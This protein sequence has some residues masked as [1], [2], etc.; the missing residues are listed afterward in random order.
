MFKS[1][2]KA[3]AYAEPTHTLDFLRQQDIILLQELA[4]NKAHE[5]A[6]ALLSTHTVWYTT[7]ERYRRGKG[8]AIALHNKLTP[9]MHSIR[10]LNDY[11]FMHLQLKG[12]LPS[13][14]DIIHIICCYIPHSK[15]T[16]LQDLDLMARFNQLTEMI[17]TITASQPNGLIIVAGDFNAKVGSELSLSSKAMEAIIDC[18]ASAC[19]TAQP[20][21]CRDQRHPELDYSGTLLNDMCS[22]THMINLTGLTQGDSPAAA[23]FVSHQDAQARHRLDHVLVSPST[24]AYLQ[25]HQVAQHILGSDHL[26]VQLSLDLTHTS[27]VSPVE[28]V[29]LMQF[30]PSRNA[31]VIQKYISE[32]ASMGFLAQMRELAGSGQASAD[33]LSSAMNSAITK[34]A[35]AAGYR[36]RSM[37]EQSPS[38]KA[39]RTHSKFK[40]WHDDKCKQ[41]QQQIRSL[42]AQAQDPLD[43][44]QLKALQQVYRS[45]VKQLLRKHKAVHAKQQA[46]AWRKNRNSFWRW[47]K[48]NGT[49]C[50]F[51]ARTIAEHFN[52]KLNSFPGAPAAPSFPNEQGQQEALGDITS[53][54]PS[55]PEIVAAIKRMDSVAAGADG[56]PTA[57]Y[58]PSLSPSADDQAPA[59][60]PSQEEQSSGEQAVAN[61]AEGLHLIYA[62]ISATRRVPLEWRTALLIPI[63][64]GKGQL[65][66]LSSYRPLSVPTVACR[67]WSCIMNQRL[68]TACKDILPDTMFG[69]RP[70]RRTSDPLFVLRHLIDMH[71]ADKGNRFAVAFMDLSG[72]YD[73]I[74]RERLFHKLKH[75]GMSD[76][77]ISTLKHLYAGTQCIV[78]CEKGTHSPFSIGVGLR[79][80]CPL[81]TT[82]FNLYIWDLHK[83]LRSTGAGVRIGDCQSA[84][85]QLI[86]DLAYADDVA[87]CGSN[88]QQLQH[89]IDKFQ[90]YCKENGLAVNPDK[91]E[92]V[93]FAKNSRAW[94]NHQWHVDSVPLPKS[95]KFKYLGVELHGTQGIKAAMQQRYSCMVAAQSTINRRLRELNAPRDPALIADLFDAITAASGSYGCEI[96]STPF[97]HDWHLRDCI[98]QRYQCSVYKHALGVRR[99]TGSLLVLLEMGRYPLQISW[100]QRTINYWN[101]LVIDKAN[102]KILGTCLADNVLHGVQEGLTCWSKELLDGLRFVAPERDWKTHMSQL[103]PIESAKGIALLA[104]RKFVSDAMIKFDGDP[105]EP[106]C[107]YRQHNSYTHWMYVTPAD[108]MLRP[109]SYVGYSM[110][111]QRKQAIAR[112]RLGTAQV[113]VHTDHGTPYQQRICQRCTSGAVDSIQHLL[114]ECEHAGLQALR[115][116]QHQDLQP[117][118]VSVKELMRLAYDD[119]KTECLSSYLYEVMQFIC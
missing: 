40:V 86:T 6:Q 10:I 69:F 46:L 94:L 34:A 41:L 9:H 49:H 71:K 108:G 103:L 115:Q 1:T 36:S 67:I 65:A 35:K 7:H 61:I 110:P 13:P 104:K 119:S 33:Q 14:T 107:P 3:S 57:L 30:V 79:Q 47:Y 20:M 60:T 105:T 112:C 58:K 68:L 15:S 29:D 99:S 66:E 106:E 27:Q 74:D 96:W 76:P 87:L 42:A 89:L 39:P 52:R 91:C 56:L 54:A 97:L 90:T 113:R 51:S 95:R 50:P 85:S 22:A 38:S 75:L 31:A 78:R 18:S 63:Y 64:K 88:P 72:A 4:S 12:M 17:D 32:T 80:G 116:A 118:L 45:R 77:T 23:S 26:P 101:K 48:P 8:I 11:Q 100:L 2:A 102:S 70:H 5:H 59:A 82:L 28:Q 111:L 83:Q 43:G 55:V 92:V 21:R 98:P 62:A 117:S 109:P 44:E 93:V 84:I 53:A 19:L 16:Q 114:C 73:S 25:Q 81:S 37:A 24:V